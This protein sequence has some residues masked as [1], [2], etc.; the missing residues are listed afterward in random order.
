MRRCPGDSGLLRCWLE[1]P[2]APVVGVDGGA[3]GRWEYG[4]MVG[5]E[6]TFCP[7]LG[8]SPAVSGESSMVRSPAAVL[9]FGM[10]REGRPS[11]RPMSR[12]RA[13]RASEIRR[14]LPPRYGSPSRPGRRPGLRALRA[15]RQGGPWSA[16]ASA[17]WA[18][19]RQHGPHGGVGPPHRGW[20]KAFLGKARDELPE[21]RRINPIKR[22]ALEERDGEPVDRVLV[23]GSG[24][25]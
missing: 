1:D 17:T 6:A 3:H 5:R 13:A 2:P 14:P 9:D 11:S 21:Q 10:V 24:V 15:S 8:L 23:A 4:V 12:Q 16:Q 22:S 18:C 20:S 25:L 7:A 19:A